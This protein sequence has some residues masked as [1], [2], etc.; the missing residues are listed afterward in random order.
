M[1]TK[2]THKYTVF[3]FLLLACA[4]SGCATSS[5][6]T[7]DFKPGTDFK[8]YKTFA[9]HNFSSEITTSNQ[10]AVQ[11]SIEQQ[12]ALQGFKL[13]NEMPDMVLDLNIIKHVATP[14]STGVGL[15]IGIPLGRHGGVG[16]GTNNLLNRGD[17]LAGLIILDIT[18]KDSNEVIWRG[19]VD[20]VPLSYFSLKNQTDLNKVLINLIQQFP[21]K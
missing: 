18:A 9:W 8:A 12:L 20:E 5:K 6:V 16:I 7:Q 10:I 11:H 21:P 4:L 15:S 1:F 2:H 13:V 19:S 3:L 14:S 17:Q